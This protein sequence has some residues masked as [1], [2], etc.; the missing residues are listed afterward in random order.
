MSVTAA[1]PPYASIEDAWLYLAEMVY[2]P[3]AQPVVLDHQMV[4][5]IFFAG[6]GAAVRLLGRGDES[7]SSVC[8]DLRAFS[9][10]L[11]ETAAKAPG[12]PPGRVKGN[13]GAESAET[14]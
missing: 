2:C 9:G 7:A 3:G 5:S 4:R 11:R 1:P 14:E 13:P 10:S 8:R 6:A 12:R